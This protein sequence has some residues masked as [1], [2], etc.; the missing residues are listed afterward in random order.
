VDGDRR[1]LAAWGGT[2]LLA[3]LPLGFLSVFFAWPLA[4]IL[5]RSLVS[6]GSLDLPFDVLTSRTTGEI[7][8]FTLW[9]AAVSTALTLVAA[10][11]LTWALARFSFAGRGLVEALVLL[12]FVLPTVVVATAFVAVL[13]DGAEHTVWAILLAHVFFNVA[14]VVRVVGPYWERLDARAWDVA[15]T[16]GAGPARRFR[17]LTLPALQP[18]L[19]AAASI[20][21][22]FCFTS[23][24]VILI[25]GGPRYATLETEI[26]N[27]AA[28]AFDLRT[29]AALALLQLAAVAMVIGIAGRLERRLG[30]GR[31]QRATGPRRPA[32]RERAV[33]A[34]VVLLTL[35]LLAAP[36]ATLVERSLAVPGGH[37]FDHY[38]ALARETPAMLVAP[39][40]A[41]LNSLLFAGAATSL[42]LAVGIATAVLAT[43]RGGGTLDAVVMLPLGASAAMLGF[44]FLLAFDDPPLD[45]RRSA[46]LV[47]VAQALVATPFV[48]RTLAPA[49]RAVD[50]RLREAA[51]VLGATP[52]QVRREIDLPLVARALG[53][54][55]GLAFAVCLGEFGA[56][57]F[58]A[59]ADW[60][61]LPVAIFRFLG[62]PGAANAG[63]AMALCVVLMALTSAAALASERA[64][65]GRGWRR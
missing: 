52:A 45:L 23:F 56:T 63:E 39:W 57:V 49:L 41:A 15:A 1:P 11:P 30:G 46:W 7:A 61:T 8:W 37:G 32:A 17:T 16:L 64:L 42:A 29:A 40:H 22:L 36:L 48:V 33:V 50:P 14:V 27:Q 34:G 20:V 55:V 12:P 53:V 9:Q 38:R 43:R 51:A 5:E 2:A 28:R 60:P 35:S 62:R 47:A 3:A 24:G 25:L 26:Y 54:A 21:F 59:R 18:A 31:R 44:G 10:L 13:P 6:G 58:V 19:A 65:S 4:A